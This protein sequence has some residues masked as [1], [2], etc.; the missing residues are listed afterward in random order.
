MTRFEGELRAVHQSGGTVGRALDSISEY[1]AAKQRLSALPDKIRASTD[2]SR[3][4]DALVEAAVDAGKPLNTP[5]I[6]Q[7]VA[8]AHNQVLGFGLVADSVGRL[9]NLLGSELDALVYEHVDTL[10]AVLNHEL[11]ELIRNSHEAFKR[12]D[13]VTDFETAYRRGLASEFE[14]LREAGQVYRRLRSEQ[15]ILTEKVVG[16]DIT[17]SGLKKLPS[18]HIPDTAVDIEHVLLELGV[19]VDDGVSIRRPK[20]SLPADWSTD[21][22]FRWSL[23][24]QVAWIP[25]GAELQAARI[26]QA[27]QLKAAADW[28]GPSYFSNK[29]QGFATSKFPELRGHLTAAPAVLTA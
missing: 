7:A 25:N 13:G 12:L 28:L 4:V 19:R 26:R 8:D 24:H 29:K 27:T 23:K 17:R 20:S 10:F 5:E 6:R 18:A 14:D 22:G 2:S 9:R 3:E 21:E 15:Y 16:V 11:Q 1:A